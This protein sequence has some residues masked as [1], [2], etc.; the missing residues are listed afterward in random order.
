VGD[1]NF[2]FV[3]AHRVGDS[4]WTSK[5]CIAHGVGSYKKYRITH[6]VG[7]CKKCTLL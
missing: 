7:S 3:G 4:V 2:T 6:S 5:A 1:A